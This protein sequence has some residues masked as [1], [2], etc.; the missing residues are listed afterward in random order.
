[1]FTLLAALTL[2]PS[3][4]P[5]SAQD[6]FSDP[7]LLYGFYRT[8]FGL[9]HANGGHGA[10][11]VKKFAG[12]V[13]LYVDDRS[14]T[15]KGASVERFVRSVDGAVA[16]LDLRIVPRALDAN[17]TVYVVRR[18]DYA[19]TIRRDI[20]ASQNAPILG[21]CMVRVL[22][23]LSGITRAQAVIVADEGEFLFQRCM[24]EEILQG[25]G[26]LNDDP[27]LA[28]SVFNDGSP[29]AAFMLHDRYI[30]NMLYH[31][32]IVPGMTRG[33]VDRVINA[34]LEDVR[35]VVR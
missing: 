32:R 19:D 18:A 1:M 28:A 8:V 30:L 9:E 11:V 31:P 4:H 21:R 22:T 12:P 33:D 6:R 2:C 29:H 26:P 13:L 24:V 16:G 10:D 34:V 17:F 20:Y 5:A 23:E 15:G 27:T 14:G 3:V 7:A 35:Q 25:L